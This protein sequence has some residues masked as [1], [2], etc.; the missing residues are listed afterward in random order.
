[1][2]EKIS[3]TLVLALPYL[4]PP[5]NIE[6]D[7]S[8]YSMGPVLMQNKKPIW[9]HFETFPKPVANYPT[10]DK[11]L[12]ALVQSVKKRKHN[13]MGKEAIIH[14]DHQPLQ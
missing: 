2:K 5:F 13:L 3:S 1:M 9:Y 14:I 4:Q 11:E 8:G 7:T 10:Y 6:I 12:Y